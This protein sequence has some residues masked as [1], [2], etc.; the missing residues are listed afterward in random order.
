MPVCSAKK[1]K[2]NRLQQLQCDIFR[3]KDSCCWSLW[4]LWFM[5]FA[6]FWELYVQ[7]HSIALPGLLFYLYFCV[8]GYSLVFSLHIYHK[9]ASQDQTRVCFHVVLP[10]HHFSQVHYFSSI[11]WSMCKSC[12]VLFFLV[13]FSFFICSAGLHFG[14]PSHGF[15]LDPGRSPKMIWPNFGCAANA[16]HIFKAALSTVLLLICVALDGKWKLSL[17]ALVH[18]TQAEE[19]AERTFIFYTFIFKR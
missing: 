7:H 2:T 4:M 15:Y 19:H 6:F 3:G 5:T 14:E 12:L 8:C 18:C 9:T 11:S 1:R 13:V 17:T 10:V 16:C